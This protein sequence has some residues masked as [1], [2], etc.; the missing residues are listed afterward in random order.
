MKTKYKEVK[1]VEEIKN[2]FWFDDDWRSVITML[3]GFHQGE[4]NREP[5]TEKDIRGPVSKD[6][7][8]NPLDLVKAIRDK[9]ENPDDIFHQMLLLSAETIGEIDRETRK[10][11]K[12]KK[13]YKAI[14]KD[15]WD[16]MIQLLKE[17]Q[18]ELYKNVE[19]AFGVCLVEDERL[20]LNL[21][22]ILNDLDGRRKKRAYNVLGYMSSFLPKTSKIIYQRA[23]A[24]IEK[25]LK[26][27]V[28]EGKDDGGILINKSNILIYSKEL[29]KI[30]A[31][32]LT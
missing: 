2:H 25:I 1:R 21:I 16:E 4:P 5:N 24:E 27:I 23:I 30:M 26:L 19:L 14:E 7:N 13:R 31:E 3:G 32:K 11:E 29:T 15:L 10:S 17:E 9:T 28:S 22:D 20:L 6:I 18:V 8:F 12:F